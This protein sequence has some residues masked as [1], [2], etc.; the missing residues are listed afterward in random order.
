MVILSRDGFSLTQ[1]E[2]P[3]AFRGQARKWRGYSRRSSE[4]R[5]INAA[6]IGL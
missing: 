5:K 4:I 6:S 1:M 3:A 2:Q